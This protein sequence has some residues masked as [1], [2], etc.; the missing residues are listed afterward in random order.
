MHYDSESK[1]RIIIYSG[2]IANALLAKGYQMVQVRPDRAEQDKI[3]FC[4]QGRCMELR[5][6]C[7]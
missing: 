4:V 2:R 5:T 1:N 6:N 3:G 7:A